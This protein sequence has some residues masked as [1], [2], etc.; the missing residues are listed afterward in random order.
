MTERRDDDGITGKGARLR[1]ERRAGKERRRG[2][3]DRREQ[4]RFEPETDPRRSG[5]DR[6]RD[7][8]QWDGAPDVKRRRRD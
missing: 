8:T 2:E 4:I 5:E 3:S 1:V 6:R 7:S